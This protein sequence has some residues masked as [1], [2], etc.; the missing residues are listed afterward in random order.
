MAPPS[1]THRLRESIRNI[2]SSPGIHPRQ[3]YA[4]TLIT[5]VL[6]FVLL[7]RVHEKNRPLP[8]PS[9]RPLVFEV[10]GNVGK[11]GVHIARSDKLAVLHAI[12]MAGGVTDGL[13]NRISEELSGKEL[14]TGQRIRV[15]RHDAGDIEVIL[16]PMEAAAW[17]ILGGKLDLNEATEE[18]LCLVPRMR[19]EFAEAIVSKRSQRPWKNLHEIQEIPGIGPKT[20]EKWK[21]SLEVRSSK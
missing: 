8:L 3:L 2:L 10:Q 19:K 6:F 1:S 12:D 21:D 9:S 7:L 5:L 15:S 14:S 17:L 4:I 11:P 18:E 13:E 16:E 20:V